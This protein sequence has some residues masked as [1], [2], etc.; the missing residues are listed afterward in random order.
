MGSSNRSAAGAKNGLSN[1]T[2]FHSSRDRNRV[3]KANENVNTVLVFGDK[4]L[5]RIATTESKSIAENVNSNTLIDLYMHLILWMHVEILFTFN[6]EWKIKNESL[7]SFHECW[8]S[9]SILLIELKLHPV[10]DKWLPCL[11]SE[12]HRE[13]T[14]V[15][16]K[17]CCN[18]RATRRMCHLRSS[19][20]E[21][22][23]MWKGWMSAPRAGGR[24]W[25]KICL[26]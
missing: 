5:K 11:A 20:Q 13:I 14:L 7:Y 24:F 1:M 16:R 23:T 6:S 22:K 4:K 15:N 17:P 26:R 8:T 21:R 18:P 25:V 3:F 9:M 10:I 12:E 2:S 19:Q